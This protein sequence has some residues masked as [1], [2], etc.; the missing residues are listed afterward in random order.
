MKTTR[1]VIA[2]T[3]SWLGAAACLGGT[4]EMEPKVFEGK[5]AETAL[6]TLSAEASEPE[7]VF[8]YSAVE[9]LAAVE[10][11]GHGFYAHGLSFEAGRNVGIPF[12]RMPVPNNP[13]P[14]PTKAED[15]R[16]ILETF[17]GR[18]AAIDARLEKIGDKEFKTVIPL[19]AANLD[20]IGQGKP[21]ELIRFGPFFRRASG[22][23]R[24]AVGDPAAGS[25]NVPFVVAFDQTDALWLRAYTH[26]L[27]GLADILLAHDGGELFGA[28]GQLF[29]TRA[30][31][32]FARL[33]AERGIKRTGFEAEQIADLIALV[34]GV[35]LPVTD[36]ARLARAR[37]EL[38]AM[39]RLSRATLASAAAETDDDREWLPSPAQNSVFGLRLN[40]EQ[41]AAWSG[42][43]AEFEALLE[44]KKLLPHWRFAA[45]GE[46]NYGINLRRVFEES[47]RTDLIGYAQGA[48]A[49]PYFETG[50]TTSLATW[51]ELVRVFGGN[52]LG[53]ALW[54]N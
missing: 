34:H 13:D 30:D 17:H 53:Y 26:L 46:G 50:S 22:T 47:R 43:L 1:R 48:A 21:E 14:L 20:F 12:L 54:I 18:L 5:G 3:L 29:F 32:A 7:A 39:V 45:K 37:E 31:T 49:L 38:L 24:P 41:S 42:V 51:R 10:Q 52:F 15:V 44:G 16:R 6:A 35:D 36:P 28:T 9:L 2:F 8:A 23:D 19:G 25:D 4:M 40:T 11:L 33:V 27:R